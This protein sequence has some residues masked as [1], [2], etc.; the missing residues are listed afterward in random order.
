LLA[1]TNGRKPF[2]AYSQ[3]HVVTSYEYLSNMRKNVMDKKIVK[4]ILKNKKKEKQEKKP[5]NTLTTLII[6][7]RLAKRELAKQQQAN[8]I[9]IW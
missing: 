2:V 6:V 8:F 4:Q 5:R 1:R 7:E 9:V 3:N